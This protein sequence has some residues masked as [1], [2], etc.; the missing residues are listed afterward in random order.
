MVFSLRDRFNRKNLVLISLPS[1][2]YKKLF[3]RIIVMSFSLAQFSTLYSVSS[4]SSER[5]IL[6]LLKK[7]DPGLNFGGLV[8]AN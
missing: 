5:L 7:I 2:S 1:S 8:S 3:L 4:L 6:D